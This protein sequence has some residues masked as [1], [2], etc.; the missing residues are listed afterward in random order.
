MTRATVGIIRGGTSQE[1]PYSLKTGAAMMDALSPEEYD[2]RDILV[3]KEGVWYLRGVPTYPARAL[4]QVDV[5]LNALHGGVG[6][7]GS[8]VRILESLGMPYVG[9]E[10]HATSAS[11]NKLKARTLLQEAGIRMPRGVGFTLGTDIT[12]GEM[13]R[14]VFE[15]MG[16]PYIVKPGSE[17]GSHGVSYVATIYELPEVLGDVLDAFGTAIVEEYVL[18]AP[19]V[20]GVIEGYRG[21]E[22]YTLPPARVILPEGERH[23]AT[24]HFG[25]ALKYIL[26]SDFAHTEKQD[27]EDTARR[28]HRALGLTHM[29]SA[30]FIMTKRGPVLL[31]VDVLPHLHEHAVFPQMLTTVG[32]SVAEFL[33]HTIA[34]AR[35]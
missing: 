21:D 19:A 29:S 32:S 14:A 11:F 5:V 15:Q 28:A 4:A 34:R 17:S 30:D 33:K 23:T 3:D 16:P 2:I 8:V 18:G 6:E 13:A 20:V 24:H 22:L 1:Y 7:D 9:S 12:T 10:P 35:A 27:L 26:P 25:G 31:E